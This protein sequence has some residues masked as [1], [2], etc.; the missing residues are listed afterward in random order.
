MNH[1][2]LQYGPPLYRLDG[3]VLREA[4]LVAMDHAEESE[5]FIPLVFEAYESL[6]GLIA[7]SN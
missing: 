4:V 2:V 5:G 1:V 7:E 6:V 3:M